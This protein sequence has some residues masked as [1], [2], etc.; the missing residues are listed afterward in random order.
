MGHLNPADPICSGYAPAVT[1]DL[2]G[3][4]FNFD[5]PDHL[6]ASDGTIDTD[7]SV[8]DAGTGDSD[9]PETAYEDAIL[10]PEDGLNKA[11]S[12]LKDSNKRKKVI[13]PI[14]TGVTSQNEKDDK[15][16]FLL[17]NSLSEFLR[18]KAIWFIEDD[19]NDIESPKE[20]P[21]VSIVNI[22]DLEGMALIDFLTILN[23]Q[24]KSILLKKNKSV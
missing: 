6:V 15:T 3:T 13:Y 20:S 5:S 2:A 16:R 10:L 12:E 19:M 17:I 22:S 7:G 8:I 18:K 4:S 23:N 1:R 14:I 11:N 9:S 24:K 21:F